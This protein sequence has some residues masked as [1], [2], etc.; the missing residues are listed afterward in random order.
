M[1]LNK[2]MNILKHFFTFPSIRQID[3]KSTIII[4]EI[5]KMVSKMV[6][7]MVLKNGP[8]NGPKNG[9]INSFFRS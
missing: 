7:K 4:I 3:L 8:K 2:K 1:D 9:Q 5:P 6:P